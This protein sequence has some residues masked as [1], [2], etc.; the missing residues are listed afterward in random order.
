MKSLQRIEVSLFVSCR[1]DEE[2][3]IE[4]S[5]KTEKSEREKE[6][7]RKEAGSDVI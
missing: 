4:T 7:G 2:V 3:F 5:W 1:F 6:C